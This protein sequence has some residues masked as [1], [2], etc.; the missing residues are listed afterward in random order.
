MR[1]DPGEERTRW[2]LTPLYATPA[3]WA[4]HLEELTPRIDSFGERP[5][6]AGPGA[7]PCALREVL[8]Y[9]YQLT[10]EVE[11]LL[12]YASQ[13]AD[14][15]LRDAARAH[16]LERAAGLQ[17]RHKEAHQ[18]LLDCVASLPREIRDHPTLNLFRPVLDQRRRAC[19]AASESGQARDLAGVE[20]DA[21]ARLSGTCER[22]FDSL[23]GSELPLPEV[24]FSSGETLRLTSV[25]LARWRASPAGEDRRRVLRAD[26]ARHARFLRT[27]TANF[28]THLS[29]VRL[30]AAR[31][32]F[33]SSLEASLAEDDVPLALHDRLLEACR[34]H[35]SLHH[36]ILAFQGERRGS[37][38]LDYHDLGASP[39]DSE[40]RFS[41]PEGLE[42]IREALSPLG[43]EY[44]AELDR[45]LEERWIDFLPREGK[46][47]RGY[48]D[49]SAFDVHPYVLVNWHGD[50]G[51][52][53]S[54][55]H[56][57][58][59]AMHHAFT[60]RHQ[61]Y[62]RAGFSVLVSEVAAAVNEQLLLEYLRDRATTQEERDSTLWQILEE[63]R[64][65]IFR[66]AM[67]AEFERDVH[68]AHGAG[69]SWSGRELSE[70]Y[71]ELCRS[72]HDHRG[73]TCRVPEEVGV[74]WAT[75]S[76]FLDSF[77]VY[78]YAAAGL[79]G[80]SWAS[81]L[82]TDPGSVA[83]FLEVL[84][85]GGSVPPVELLRGAGFDPLD[86]AVYRRGFRRIRELLLRAGTTSPEESEVPT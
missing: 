14:E 85:S 82:L 78:Q 57:L 34:A 24:E 39:P 7:E 1:G 21:L 38:P 70:H 71:L 28:D 35:L 81:Q 33:A 43:P 15:D 26:L 30:Q 18:A 3:A 56:E 63:L 8:E 41:L 60:R 32:G 73:G 84:R 61:P 36:E 68:A 42:L 49:G 29:L 54:L 12:V 75:N 50:L 46:Y 16:D 27:L 23:A 20:G 72:F 37:K 76:H 52:L 59:H 25:E 31:R 67:L 45:A 2:D 6:P 80:V 17:A 4:E 69:R 19:P 86:P 47:P 48:T 51:S 62:P 22:L 10:R 11:R 77:Y 55:V 44:R 79:L 53:R 64:A 65:G 13:R 9:S 5:L 58:A 74:E 66:Q 83:P 40:R